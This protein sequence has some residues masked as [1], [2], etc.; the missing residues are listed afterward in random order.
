VGA[1]RLLYKNQEL[2]VAAL[3]AATSSSVVLDK[4]KTQNPYYDWYCDFQMSTHSFENH[5]MRKQDEI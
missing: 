1:T 4:M 5:N 2:E 3:R